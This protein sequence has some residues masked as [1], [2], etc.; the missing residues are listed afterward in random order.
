MKKKPIAAAAAAAICLTLPLS[1]L[2][3]PSPR[4][5]LLKN[6]DKDSV[7]Y[8]V[9]QKL[10]ESGF[11]TVSP[12]GYYG[13]DT[14]AAVEAYQKEN[15]LAV[16]GI[17]GPATMQSLLGSALQTANYIATGSFFQEGDS[18]LEVGALQ[19]RLMELG[20]YDY[21]GFTG[22]YGPVTQEA[23]RLFQRTNGLKQDGIAGAETLTLLASED[24]LPY[25]VRLEDEGEDVRK[26]QNRLKE[27]GYLSG[28][29]DGI[30][31][32]ETQKAVVSFQK[33]NGLTAD[34]IFGQNTQEL[35]YSPSAQ[36]APA[37]KSSSGSSEKK[38]SSA[39]SGSSKEQETSS[40]SSSGDVSQ[41]IRFAKEQLG[42]KYVWSTE[43]PNSFDCSG[44]VY[45]VL[46]NS[47]VSTGRY[48][49]AGFSQ[50]SS[51]EKIESKGDLQPG[52]LIFFTAPGSSRIGHTGIWL[53]NNQYIHAS[54][55]AGKVVISSAGSYFNENFVFGRRVF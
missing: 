4:E 48:S 27:L 36:A 18:S 44:F 55:S 5:D 25:T 34:G 2:A 9:Q 32:A 13:T 41:M 28:S 10:Y 16:D 33:Q 46:K 6:G 23:I 54:T 47:G 35:L 40:A 51:W 22:N 45:Y 52:D 3:A 1:V 8:S 37:S 29:A 21:D 39:S 12:T 49:A 50:V 42:K 53:G 7:V 19:R 24:A 20:Y 26:I 11:L 31:G 30:Y 15:Q 17:A 14:Q 38:E 43:G